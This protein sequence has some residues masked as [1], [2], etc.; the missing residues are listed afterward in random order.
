MTTYVPHPIDTSQVT[1][2]DRQRLLIETLA[3]NTHDVW[4]QKR[5]ADGWRHGPNRNDDAKTHPCLV[6][7][8]ELP[9]SEKDYDRIVV[10]Q[11]IR[12]AIALGYRIEKT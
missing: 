8:S 3:K 7:Y 1:L 9:E 5:L 12:A 10:E 6:P 4:A 2:D 11:V